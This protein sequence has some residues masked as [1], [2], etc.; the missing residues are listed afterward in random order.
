MKTKKSSFKK[1]TLAAAAAEHAMNM[2]NPTPVCDTASS[3]CIPTPPPPT[4]YDRRLILVNRISYYSS[5]CDSLSER[6]D[7]ARL[8]LASAR[9][10]LSDINREIRS[11]LT[12]DQSR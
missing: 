10:E 12:L 5:I 9:N 4:P 7:Q 11:E 1:K 8:D 6:F 2:A 3:G